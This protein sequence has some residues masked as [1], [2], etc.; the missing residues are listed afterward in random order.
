VGLEDSYG[1]RDFN[2]PSLLG[3]SQRDRL[4]HD[5]SVQSYREAIQIHAGG[6]SL[7]LSDSEWSDLKSFL[8]SL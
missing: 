6:H 2:P 4:L 8:D 5:R 3:V 1:N 7:S